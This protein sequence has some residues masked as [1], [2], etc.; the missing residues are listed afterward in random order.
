MRRTFGTMLL[1]GRDVARTFADGIGLSRTQ[2]RNLLDA[3]LAGE[4]VRAGRAHL[5]ESDIVAG[6]MRRELMSDAEIEQLCRRGPFIAR[7][8]PERGFRITSGEWQQAAA[9][10][11][12]YTSALTRVWM[13]IERPVRF[14][15]VA[16]VSSFV[17]W[18]ADIVGWHGGA[19]LQ[20]DGDP[21][22]QLTCF[23]FEA[24]GEWFT[25]FV[26]RRIHR[27]PGYPSLVHG[28]PQAGP[29]WTPT[30]RPQA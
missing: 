29:A 18:G 14:P 30:M 12:W 6:L 9:L 1:S 5:Y 4:P 22:Q 8:G 19:L 23:E 7:V 3:G 26:D 27:G 20:G 11:E 21:R 24:P 13:A 15:F 10:E 16:T 2:V 17:V 28:A 25:G